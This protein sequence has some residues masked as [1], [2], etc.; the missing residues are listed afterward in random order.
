MKTFSDIWQG[1]RITKTFLVHF[2]FQSWWLCTISFS[3]PGQ[4]SLTSLA[5]PFSPLGLR[6]FQVLQQCPCELSQICLLPPISNFFFI[7]NF[8][9][10]DYGI[11][12]TCAPS[13]P[14][15]LHPFFSAKT[16]HYLSA[17]SAWLN[18]LNLPLAQSCQYKRQ[19]QRHSM[20]VCFAELAAGTQ[21]HSKRH[22]S[23]KVRTEIR[24]N[25]NKIQKR[26]LR[27]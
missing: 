8:F 4:R 5:Q 3:L 18:L 14:A 19:N 20:S 26:T 27:R 2:S 1:N 13:D 11:S 7:S 23:L 12:G 15:L 6:H 22:T 17:P 16:V 21:F 9:Y 24:N 10:P 25:P